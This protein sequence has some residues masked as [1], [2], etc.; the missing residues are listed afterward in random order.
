MLSWASPPGAPTDRAIRAPPRTEGRCT[1]GRARTR[2]RSAACPRSG[3]HRNPKAATTSSSRG[4]ND[5]AGITAASR[6]QGSWDRLPHRRSG[7]LSGPRTTRRVVVVG[8]ARGA[9]RACRFRPGDRPPEGGVI[10]CADRAVLVPLAAQRPPPKWHATRCS[11]AFREVGGSRRGCLRCGWVDR[12]TVCRPG[13]TIR[14]TTPSIREAKG[15]SFVRHHR[16]CARSREPH[17][18]DAP[19]S[20]ARG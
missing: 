6:C 15:G 19:P 17:C 13:R 10:S 4:R 3:C 8:H 1:A 7:V 18:C 14:A 5:R 12:V 11:T 16:R 2:G 20:R 9:P